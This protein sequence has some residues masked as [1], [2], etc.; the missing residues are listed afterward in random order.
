MASSERPLG[1]LW[2]PLRTA[3][4]NWAAAQRIGQRPLRVLSLKKDA[5]GRFFASSRCP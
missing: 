4:L 1:V 5:T 2:R 3:A